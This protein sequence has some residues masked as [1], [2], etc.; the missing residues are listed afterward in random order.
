MPQSP[1]LI[2]G[3]FSRFQDF[4][5]FGSGAALGQELRAALGDLAADF[6]GGA[7][8][9]QEVLVFCLAEAFLIDVEVAEFHADGVAGG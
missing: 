4:F 2:S 5:G 8:H 7:V 1:E 6:G 9:G 3:G